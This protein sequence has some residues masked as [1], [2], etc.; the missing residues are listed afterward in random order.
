M[1]PVQLHRRPTFVLGAL[2]LLVLGACS[3]GSDDPPPPTLVP[4][5]EVATPTLAPGQARV[6]DLLERAEASW[7][8]VTNLR[9]VFSS[10]ETS[11]SEAET[12]GR[13]VVVEEVKPDRR[14]VVVREDGIVT[15]EQIVVDGVIYLRGSFVAGLVAPNVGD[16]TWVTVDPAVVP[17]DTPVGQQVAALNAPI[18]APYQAVR[19]ETRAL[20]ATPA[21]RIDIAGRSC[22]AFT[23]S[24]RDTVSG[25]QIEY[26]L[27]LDDTDRLC[28]LNQSAGAV[29]NRTVFTYNVP[30]LTIEAPLAATPVSGT[31]EG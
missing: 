21:G 16:Q 30:Q 28:A 15:D 4:P 24:A 8:G 29:T 2:V 26:T 19:P 20:P 18:S 22:Q 10:T 14:R 23:F 27:A 3:S 7:D 11:S 17:P 25:G 13:E 31:P 5:T 12:G 6:G 1:P 9:S